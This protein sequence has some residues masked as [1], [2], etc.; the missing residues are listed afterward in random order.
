MTGAPL[1][2]AIVV[3]TMFHLV[4]LAGG[5]ATRI[6]LATAGLRDEDDHW[7]ARPLAGLSSEAVIPSLAPGAARTHGG[8]APVDTYAV[9]DDV[10]VAA[11][12][13]LA[14]AGD[15]DAFG[16]LFEHFRGP[17]YRQLFFL[18]RSVA[19]AEDLTSETFLRA[20]R[21]MGR[22]QMPSTYFGPWL[23]KI[24]RNLAMDHW[25]SKTTQ[26]EHPTDDFSWWAPQDDGR[27]LTAALEAD[28]LREALSLLPESQRRVLSMRFLCQMSIEETT[29]EMGCTYGATKQLQ[30]RGL[31]SLE[32]VLR[33][34]E[35]P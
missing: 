3:A 18:T 31:R 27:E 23:R 10:R 22:E 20:L 19:T 15:P 9:E 29:A 11:L 30:W 24:A 17:I 8:V 26:V 33:A 5:S 35:G 16:Q 13:D 12:V 28:S 21:A 25:T 32:R 6:R 1:V 4:G 14:Q 2:T 34:Q 7:A